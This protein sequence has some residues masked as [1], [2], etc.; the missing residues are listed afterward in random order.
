MTNTEIPLFFHFYQ[1]AVRAT[2]TELYVFTWPN[3]CEKTEK[4]L[5]LLLYVKWGSMIDP[6]ESI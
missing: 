5:T 3:F 4:F 6:I 2:G 1:A